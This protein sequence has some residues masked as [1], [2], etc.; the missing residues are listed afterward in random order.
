M[1]DPDKKGINSLDIMTINAILT[2]LNII[3][4][5]N[6]DFLVTF[7]GNFYAELF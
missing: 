1:L 5:K 4:K 3:L 6:K 7:E 2:L